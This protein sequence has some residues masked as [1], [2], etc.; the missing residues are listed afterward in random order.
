[1]FRQAIIVLAP[2]LT[3]LPAKGHHEKV[4]YNREHH[5][6][7][8][9]DGC[10]GHLLLQ[11][12]DRM[13]KPEYLRLRQTM[14]S[15]MHARRQVISFGDMADSRLSVQIKADAQGIRAI[16]MKIDRIRQILPSSGTDPLGFRVMHQ[17]W[18][19][20]RSHV[21]AKLKRDAM[22][23]RDD[24]KYARFHDAYFSHQ[25]SIRA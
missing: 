23:A 2:Q 24:R 4:R 18:N 19:R 21:L 11:Q 10:A 8:R 13:N 22:I 16:Q 17:N 12:G 14:R 15:F 5:P 25:K 1:M 9:H 3:G 7:H 6:R 20:R